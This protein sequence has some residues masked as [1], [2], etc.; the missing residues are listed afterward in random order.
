MEAFVGGFCVGTGKVNAVRSLTSARS[1]WAVGK[2]VRGKRVKAVTVPARME[3]RCEK[4]EVSTGHVIF[5][6]A[7]AFPYDQLSSVGTNNR[8]CL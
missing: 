3:M 4:V 6:Y 8:G 5:V 7:A 2:D 1:S